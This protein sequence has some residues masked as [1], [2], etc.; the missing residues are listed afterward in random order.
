MIWTQ[1]YYRAYELCLK[2]NR[3][4]IIPELAF[5]DIATLSGVIARLTRLLGC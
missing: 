4:E 1:L 3:Y 5:M 2:A